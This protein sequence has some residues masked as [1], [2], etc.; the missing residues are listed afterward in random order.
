MWS[1]GTP[2]TAHDVVFTHS[3]CKDLKLTQNWPNQCAPAGADVTAE[4]VD[5]YTVKYT[6]LNVAPSLGNWQAGIEL[7]PIMPMHFWADAVAEARAFVDGLEAPGDDATEEELAAYDEAFT[8]AR[9]T[10]YEADATDTPSGGGYITDRVELGAF[11]QRTANENYYFEGARIIEYDDGTWVLEHP[12]G[13]TWQLYGDAAGEVTLDY[14]TGPYAPN[15]VFSI[16]GSQ[17]AAFLALADG[18]VDYVLNPLGLARGLQEQ[19]EQGEGI[20]AITN[21]DYGMFYIAFN[22]REYPQN[23][24]EFRQAFDIVIDKEFVVNNVLAG[25]VFPMYSTMPPGNGFWYTDVETPYIGMSREDRV[26]LAVEVLTAGGWT[27]ETPPAWNE[28]TVDVDPG[29]GITMPDGNPMHELTILGPGPAYDPIRATFN[30]WI[31]E[32]ARELGMPVV[33]ELTG[34]NTI[35][36]PVFV[37]ADFDMYILGWSLGNVAFPDYFEAFWHSANDTAVSGNYN[38]PGFNNAEYDALVDEFMTT[39]DLIRAQEL[40][41][42]MQE[43][44]A[45]QRPYIPLFYKQVTDLVRDN[46]YLPYT[47]TLGGIVDA[48]GFQTESQP[49]FK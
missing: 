18:E 37:D 40:V 8:N 28:D 4:A 32:W 20:Q 29:V 35:L 12:N 47:E 22:M 5:D 45:D 11:A 42:S 46:I 9:R 1:D 7:A 33:S 39:G 34:F 6:Y 31:S 13:M 27:W 14:V 25:V 21:A 10:L 43:M 3:T 2:I 17:D 48:A 19:A 49:L 15:I 41:Y 30:Q 26:N 23:L 38:T 24:Y 36:G 16:Y 44:L